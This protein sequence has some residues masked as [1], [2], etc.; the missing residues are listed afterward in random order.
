MKL[1]FFPKDASF[2]ELFGQQADLILQ[3][4]QTFVEFVGAGADQDK[5]M[6]SITDLEHRGDDL[7]HDISLRLNASF[8]TPIDREDIHSLGSAMDDVLDLIQGSAERML[9]FHVGQPKE[10]LVEM[11]QITVDCAKIL[12]EGITRLPKLQD[13]TDL[14]KPLRTLESRGDQLNRQAIADLF[15]NCE[16]VQDVVSLIKWKEIIEGVEDA[17]DKFEDLFDVLENVVVKHA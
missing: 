11:A 5:V 13:M 8:V 17:I 15:R 2:F 3:A 16:T 10:A 4:C 6:L 12:K 9:L 14:R 1:S 7:F